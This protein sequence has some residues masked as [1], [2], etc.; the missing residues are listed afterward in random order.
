[1]KLNRTIFMITLL[2]V[3][4]FFSCD[5][6]D[7]DSDSSYIKVKITHYGYD[8][9]EEKVDSTGTT[10]D[11]DIVNWSPVNPQNRNHL[12]YRPD[13]TI[14]ATN[15]QKDMGDVSLES[16]TSV[17]ASFDADPNPLQ[18]GNA[19]VIKCKDGYAKFKVLD[20]SD[21]DDNTIWWAKIEYEFSST[22]QFD[23]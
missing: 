21:S 19:Y 15:S 17:P 2:T 18:I 11:G 1:M 12:W 3:T 16:I 6:K 14:D 20:L 5:K 23:K 4:I 7:D 10:N 9:S 13:Y 8:F 22:G